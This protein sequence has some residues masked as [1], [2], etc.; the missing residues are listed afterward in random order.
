MTKMEQKTYQFILLKMKKFSVETCLDKRFSELTTLGCGGKICITIYPASE[1][2]LVKCVR[3]FRRLQVTFCVLG[4]GSNVLASD[5]DYDGVVIVTTKMK[6]WRVVG[7]N[8]YALA[9]ASTVSLASDL[10]NRG[11]AG[12][13]FLA[14][15][16]ATLG[17]ATVTN[18]GCFGQQMKD[19]VRQVK[20]LNGTKIRRL[21]LKLCKFGKRKSIFSQQD[22]LV[23]LSVKMKFA[24]GSVDEI[25]TRID[26]MRASKAA[27][28]PLNFRSAGSALYHDKVAV[29]R[30]LDI[31]GLKGYTVGRAQVSTK[32]AGFVVNLDKAAS[33]DIYLI[34][35]HMQSTL[36]ERF[37]LDAHIEIRLINFAKEVSD[38]DDIFTGS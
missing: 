32:H 13:E 12:G 8:V 4:K 15:L 9:G 38:C 10:K 3:L 25:S 23:I 22:D 1:R 11:L 5:D 37:G 26:A 2:Q 27:T 6:S 7:R 19:V 30:L 20:V 21:S 29:S 33:R 18:A 31:A 34:I 36:R 17:G 24:R 28:Q 14:C 35:R 16:P